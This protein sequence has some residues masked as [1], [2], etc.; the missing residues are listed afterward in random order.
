MSRHILVLV[1][2][3]ASFLGLFSN[4]LYWLILKKKCVQTSRE[5]LELRK[6][7][8]CS[9]LIGFISFF[10]FYGQFIIIAH[11]ETTA[12]RILNNLLWACFL[13]YWINYLDSLVVS[14]NL[15]SM[16]KVIQYGCFV[17][18]IVWL[19]VAGELWNVNIEAA[20]INI[21][22]LFLLLDILFCIISLFVISLYAFHGNSQAKRRLSGVYIYGIS[23][24]LILYAAYTVFHYT[25]LFS[26]LSESSEWG[27]DP[28][29]GT[30]FF[31]LTT[32]LITLIYIYYNDIAAI[33]S[34]QQAPEDNES[35]VSGTPKSE[36]VESN[37]SES[38]A[39]QS[40]AE[41][42]SKSG[43]SRRSDGEKPGETATPVSKRELRFEWE[44]ISSEFSLTPREKEIMELVFKGYS[45]AEIADELFIS[46]NTVKHHIYNLFKK[47]NVKNRVELICFLREHP[48]KS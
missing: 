28:F 25:R 3:F 39:G 12:V 14:A 26:G 5:R 38:S 23:V 15:S 13:F 47:L 30:A 10:T 31:L 21:R 17:Y 9:L 27:L 22:A 4:F 18:I 19:L 29:N 6:F 43:R 24:A 8:I 48:S 11:P 33:F 36:S 20:K 35:L 7:M 44:L 34:M 45:N 32:N 37:V 16:K 41:S 2:I 46:Q 1:Y 42:E 40:T